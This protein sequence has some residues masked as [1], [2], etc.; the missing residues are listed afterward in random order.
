MVVIIAS[1][2][3]N[4]NSNQLKNIHMFHSSLN[5]LSSVK[6]ID[7]CFPARIKAAKLIETLLMHYMPSNMLYHHNTF[8]NLEN[9]MILYDGHL[10]KI[11]TH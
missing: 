1:N 11:K 2:D 7:L 6:Y 9:M 3:T 8:D 10:S 5:L 4:I